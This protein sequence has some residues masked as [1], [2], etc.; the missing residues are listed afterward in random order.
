MKK[1][2]LTAVAILIAAS[3]LVLVYASMRGSDIEIAL[4]SKY[5][6]KEHIEAVNNVEVAKE[7]ENAVSPD[8]L[9]M[10]KEAILENG[11]SPENEDKLVP[12]VQEYGTAN[13]LMGYSYLNTDYITWDELEGFVADIKSKGAAKAIKDHESKAVA[14]APST[15][16]R[17]QLEEWIKVKGYPTVDITA[18]D[19]LAQL[20]DLSFGEL[21]ERYESGTTI[22]EMKGELGLVNTGM[23]EYVTITEKDSELLAEKLGIDNSRAKE[24]LATIVRLGFDTSGLNEIDAK[25]E[26]ELLEKVLNEK[27]RKE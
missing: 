21:M 27:Y 18:M 16:K 2:I 23:P 15:F 11:I 8:E 9:Y 1:H 14:Y 4:S 25:N 26:Y 22:D 12:I 17:S 13:T 24:V 20:Y 5:S 6:S 7:L 3:A 10:V 19:K